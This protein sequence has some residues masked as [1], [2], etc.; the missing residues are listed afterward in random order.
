MQCMKMER[1][2]IKSRLGK[3]TQGLKTLYPRSYRFANHG[4][5]AKYSPMAV[6]VNKVLLEHSMHICFYTV[7]GCFCYNGRGASL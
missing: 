4:P 5:G 3:L 2:E 7:C 1:K 6:F